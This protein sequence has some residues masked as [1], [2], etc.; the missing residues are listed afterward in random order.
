M[1]RRINS[2]YLVEATIS[3][4]TIFIFKDRTNHILRCDNKGGGRGWRVSNPLAED[5][6][7]LN[8]Q[9]GLGTHRCDNA[10]RSLKAPSGTTEMSFPCKELRA[11]KSKIKFPIIQRVQKNSYACMKLQFIISILNQCSQDVLVNK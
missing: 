11:R 9:H 5:R 8:P 4:L 3:I 10:E 1:A 7:T 6:S 2:G